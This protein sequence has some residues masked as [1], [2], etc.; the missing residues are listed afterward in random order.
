[1]FLLS[2]PVL[3]SMDVQHNTNLR[4]DSSTN[5]WRNG[6][7]VDKRNAQ[8]YFVNDIIAATNIKTAMSYI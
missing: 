2:F 6:R 3:A 1:M 5:Q 8:I 7:S 4:L